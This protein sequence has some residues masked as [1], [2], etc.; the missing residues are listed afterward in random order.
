MDNDKKSNRQLIELLTNDLKH[1]N[2]R[3]A[4]IEVIGG[5]LLIAILVKAL[6]G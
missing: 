2:A 1:V 4:R 3:L 5:G 6:L